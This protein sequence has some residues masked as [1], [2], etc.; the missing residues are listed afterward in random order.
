[1]TWRVVRIKAPEYVVE[2]DDGKVALHG[3]GTPNVL[4]SEESAE[5]LRAQLEELD[6]RWEKSRPVTST[7]L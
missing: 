2:N 5:R 4:Y 7:T 3:D 6:V 1:M